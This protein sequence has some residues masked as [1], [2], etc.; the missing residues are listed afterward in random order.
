MIARASGLGDNT[1][2]A[3]GVAEKHD[4]RSPSKINEP[5]FAARQRRSGLPNAQP[6]R[7]LT[8]P[9]QQSVPRTRRNRPTSVG[10]ETQPGRGQRT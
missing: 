3:L 9:K 7:R 6:G 1:S 10:I 4:G 2:V 5:M 8:D